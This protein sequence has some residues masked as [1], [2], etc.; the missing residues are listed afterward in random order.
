MRKLAVI[1]C[2]LSLFV[3]CS[4]VRTGQKDSVD[5]MSAMMK[6]GFD[7]HIDET[8]SGKKLKESCFINGCKL[9][10]YSDAQGRL[11][12]VTVT[13][14]GSENGGFEALARETVKAFCNFD[15]ERIDAV[16]IRLLFVTP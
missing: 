4:C 12:N 15:D 2:F 10:L 13:Y 3:L 7:V 14:A 8:V 6:A 11:V 5:F 16:F 9:S 1:C